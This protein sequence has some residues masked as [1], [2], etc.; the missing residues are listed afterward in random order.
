MSAHN[1]I[2]QMNEAQNEVGKVVS[3]QTTAPVGGETGFSKGAL[4]TSSSTGKMYVNEG[5]EASA[6]WQVVAVGS[7]GKIPTTGLRQWYVSQ[8]TGDDTNS[9]TGPSDP[10]Q[11]LAR[12]VQ[13]LEEG[14]EILLKRGDRWRESIVDTTLDNVTIS[15]YGA[16]DLP[17]IDS[18]DN[19]KVW[20]WTQVGAFSYYT[21]TLSA[22]LLAV[23]QN[24]AYAGKI[25]IG[26]YVNGVQLLQSSS[27]TLT[28]Q[29]SYWVAN[30]G[31]PNYTP[32]GEIRVHMPLSVSPSADTTTVDI[33][34]RPFGIAL[35]DGCT[36]KGIRTMRQAHDDG[37]IVLQRD[38]LLED[39]ECNDGSK[40]N[41]YVA[42]GFIRNVLCYN[43]DK[44][45]PGESGMTGATMFV[46]YYDDPQ[47]FSVTYDRCRAIMPGYKSGWSSVNGAITGFY[48]HGE[49]SGKP[50]GRV[51]YK[52]CEVQSCDVAY[53]GDWKNGLIFRCKAISCLTFALGGSTNASTN[54]YVIECRSNLV[55]SDFLF[56]GAPTARAL[57][58]T[59][60]N[61]YLDS[62]QF[63]QRT[64]TDWFVDS[65]PGLNPAEQTAAIVAYDVRYCTFLMAPNSKSSAEGFI[66]VW[67]GQSLTMANC[68]LFADEETDTANPVGSAAVSIHAAAGGNPAATYVGNDNLYH[69]GFVSGAARQ[70]RFHYQGTD[71]FSEP[72]PTGGSSQSSLW[73]TNSA[74]G[75][76]TGTFDGSGA[77][78]PVLPRSTRLP[79]D[80][81]SSPQM[82]F[83]GMADGDSP[84]WDERV[85][86][87]R[88]SWCAISGYDGSNNSQMRVYGSGH[89]PRNHA[90]VLAIFDIRP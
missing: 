30:S 72:S 63:I 27:S 78:G 13:E 62:S 60:R 23:L 86:Y 89:F 36:I 44:R 25:H 11:T 19:A 74:G 26:V 38:S 22:G 41:C 47:T 14:D 57:Q 40:H 50:Y 66:K 53:S 90:S 16:G 31:A 5:T 55:S 37:S 70:V 68:A 85:R 2:S 42:S 29:G 17:T 51:T 21:T 88:T 52:D 67:P 32:T 20:T 84:V 73:N 80:Q 3:I 15:A 46:S 39:C 24:A 45:G 4:W 1:I 8:S 59:T 64:A 10:F 81:G 33:T 34:V 35:R 56:P 82:A 9:G 6:T 58:L 76:S 75:G 18:S 7:Q 54:T 71:Y 65:N 87:P 69:A 48:N 49:N 61:V 43:A 12:A 28:L 79:W 83:R 77:S